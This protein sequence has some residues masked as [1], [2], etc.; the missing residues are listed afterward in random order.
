[1]ANGTQVSIVVDEQAP[2]IV[3]LSMP[4]EDVLIRQPLG[5]CEAG[6]HTVTATHDGIPGTYFYFDFLE[7][8]L[9]DS[10]LPV[11]NVETKLCFATDWDTEHSLALAPER[12]AWMI[13]SLGMSARVNH[14]VGALWFFELL[15]S[16]QQYASA[17]VTFTGSPDANLITQ[18][19][20]GEAGQPASS[21]NV[22]QH[23]NLLGD[24]VD[25]LALAFALLINDGY[26]AIWAQAN[27]NQLTVYSRSLGTEGN[28]ITIATSAS[29]TNLTI[30]VS[31]ST[32][33][34]GI[35]GTWCTDL[36]AMPRLNRAVR[37]WS[38]SYFQALKGYGM[39]ATAS[40]SME[41]QFGDPS[42]EAGIAQRY[43][44]QN[45]VLLNTPSL[46]TNF[47][48]TSTA[49]WQQVYLDMANILVDAGMNPYLQFGE[50]QWWYFPYDGSGM[51]FY[52]AYTTSTFQSQYGRPMTVITTNSVD[53]KTISQEAD[54]LPGLIGNFTSQI[55][56]FVRASV[57]NCRFEVLYPVDVNSTPLNTES[58]TYTGNRN[59]DLSAT[60]IAAGATLGFP[61]SQRSHLVGIGDSS[62]SWLKEAR[63][64]QGAGFESV[65]LFA[66]DQFCL[67]G[68]ALPLSMGMRLSAQIG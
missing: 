58:F 24:T 21:Q 12:T 57:P 6:N 18:I 63:M 5:Q 55:M 2:T 28:A 38:L 40:F 7:I 4:G 3:D 17:T 56:S 52:D 31:S 45:P 60:S 20:I 30:A 54:F 36:Q 64:A 51:P 22:I 42:P 9:P 68:V 41:L 37:D 39:D 61:P 66:L 46:Q 44:S 29:T 67:I 13:N 50:V 14:Y 62:T 32:L 11:E 43:P 10:T 35:D 49:Y 59:L 47:S 53:P 15:C 48:P 27:G 65:V 33:T 1:M 25:T 34:G 8:A 16:G 23:L 26:T 19:M